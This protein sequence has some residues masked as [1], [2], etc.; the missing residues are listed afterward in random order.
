MIIDTKKAVSVFVGLVT[1]IAM[2]GATA[3]MPLVAQADTTSDLQAQ[4]AQM[5]A[6]IQVLQAQL[7][8][9]GGATVGTGYQFTALM[10]LGVTNSQVKELQKVLNMDPAT[11]VSTTGAG[12]PG[13]ETSYFGSR[14]KA[15]VIAFQSKYSLGADGIV[16][17]NTRARLNSLG[18][19]APVV[20]GVPVPVGGGI[21]VSTP[22]Q[23]QAS[24]A[25]EAA[26]RLPFTRV[27][28]TAG[29]SDVTVNGIK[30]ERTGLAQDVVFAGVVLLDENGAQVGIAKTF[31]SLHQATIGDSFVLR[32]GTSR[33]FTIAGNMKDDGV[34]GTNALAA[35]AG[36]VAYLSVNGVDTLATV[37]GT[38]PV[39]GAGHTINGSLY[40]GSVTNARG[41]LDPNGPQNKEVG[42]TGYTFSSVKFTAGSVEKI[43]VKSIRWNQSGSAA[44]SDIGNV[45]TYV[46]GT[47]YDTMVS[48]DGKYYTA[49][50]GNG[51][52]VDKGNSVEISIKADIINGSGRTIA[53]DLYKNT[54]VEITGETFGY[55]LTPPT[56]GT[57]FFATNPWY[58]ASVVTV[59]GGSATSISKS[60]TVAAQNIAI[61]VSDQPLGAFEAEIKG[62]PLTI[63]QTV[64]HFL[65]S[66]TGGQVADVTN[67]SLYNESGSIIAGPVDGSG[68]AAFGTATFTDSITL[69]TGKHVYSLKG[70]IGSDFTQNQ[71]IIA[72]TTPSSDWT[73]VTGQTTGNSITLTNGLVTLNTM[74]VKTA[75]TTV[76]VAADP[77]TQ[78][79]VMGVTGFTFANYQY[80][81]T[82]SG[83]DVKVNS[84]QYTITLGGGDTSY[85]TNCFAYNGDVKLNSNAVN[86]LTA[87]NK[88]FTFDTALVIPKGTTKTVALKCDIPSNL[89]ANETIAWGVA[90]GATMEGQGLVSGQ[91]ITLTHATANSGTITLKTGGTLTVTKDVD[92]PSYALV[93]SNTSGVT[94]GVLKF[95]ATNEGVTISEVPLQLTNEA[96]STSADLV[97]FGLYDGSTLLGSGSFA[98]SATTTF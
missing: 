79:V 3:V 52:V 53:F 67:I 60:A 89:L 48:A 91:S 81:A 68:A 90:A 22:V 39:T 71:T 18:G 78:N 51:I 37:A 69:P 5:L 12:S 97:T 65:V 61:S 88:T 33:T 27:T 15:A 11:M 41:P 6:Q 43:R 8:A 56:S 58:D 25:V 47:A 1:G 17:A 14:T 59:T 57:G 40:I 35:Y 38:F 70:K 62:E 74:T 98:G 26:A 45:K 23:P 64:F 16:G 19:T 20:P 44:S 77:A 21:S 28:L 85:P 95:K 50:F 86:P 24:L 42:T 87:G 73:G 54:D 55:G 76:T 82:A 31:N 66:G 49:T 94:L 75:T 46:D 32:A 83:E 9:A 72:S 4:I 63:T 29:S 34:L 84:A 93:P 36:Q 2:S 13:M 80:D 7:S 96:T 30:V 10:K 92:S